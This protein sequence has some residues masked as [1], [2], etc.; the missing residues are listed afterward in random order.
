MTE[1]PNNTKFNDISWIIYNLYTLILILT[2]TKQSTNQMLLLLS[3]SIVS[4]S[5]WPH[6]LQHARLPCL[7]LSPSLLKL[8]CTELVI[9]SNHLILCHPLL[10]LPSIFLINSLPLIKVE[11]LLKGILVFLIRTFFSKREFLSLLLPSPL[12]LQISSYP[13]D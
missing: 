5:L 9:L 6:G 4:N 8:I 2:N 10:L 13:T 3:H 1:W 7:S 12:S 11:F